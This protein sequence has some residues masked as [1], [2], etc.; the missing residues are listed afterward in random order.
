MKTPQSLLLIGAGNMGGALLASWA[1]SDFIDKANSAVIDPQPSDRVLTIC[2]EA[3]FPINPVEDRGYDLCVL[4]IKPQMFP[5]A[6]P[7]L[8]WKGMGDTLFLSIAAGTTIETI[9][10]LL[11]GQVRN[12]KVIRTMPN[13]PSAIGMGMTILT[14]DGSAT[15]ADQQAATALFEAAGDVVWAE[16]ED[17]LDLYMAAT[18]CGPAFVFLMAE[19]MEEALISEGVSADVARKLSI[20]TMSGSATYLAKD[21][22]APAD[23]KQAVMSPGGT[24]AEG[25]KVLDSENGYRPLMKQAIKAAYHRAKELSS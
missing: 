14:H 7:T 3:G 4:A 5:D 1:R 16:N 21:G 20:A 10:N 15:A 13:L 12:P 19:T 25:V 9:R 17:Q 6:L 23:L 11:K 22:R 8:H 18:A 2:D 24:T